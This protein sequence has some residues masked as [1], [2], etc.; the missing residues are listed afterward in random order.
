MKP[1]IRNPRAEG[2]QSGR[3][4]SVCRV[5]PI[6]VVPLLFSLSPFL[7]FALCGIG[8]LVLSARGADAPSTRDLFNAAARHLQTNQLREA[9]AQL[10]MVLQR[11]EARWQ[12]PALYNLGHVRFA[13]GVEALKKSPDAGRTTARARE[14][15]G[16]GQ[17]AIQQA[18]AALAGNNLERMIDAYQ[19]GRAVRREMR[20][21]EK[22]VRQAL[23]AHA[24]TLLRWQRAL[25][26]FS[27]AAELN[28]ADTNATHNAEVVKQH[29]AKLVDQI[30]QLQQ[31]LGGPGQTGQELKEK[32]AALKGRIPAENMPPGAAGEEEEEE[33]EPG[34]P[35]P[36]HEEGPGR[37]GEEQLPMSRDDAGRL[38]DS[39]RLDSD[40]RLPMGGDQESKPRD[41]NRPTW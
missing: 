12:P 4:R 26:D 40:R 22:A 24:A 21:A 15:A 41:R 3:C 13:Q 8:L 27:G 17:S 23:E 18:D 34:G 28:P 25:G 20:A 7:L 9:E 33:E 2:R 19:Q 30:R 37:E 16:R 36:G 31:M 1:E 39:F 11:Q 35:R 29:L 10:E 14:A 5:N 38:L 6:S 32:L